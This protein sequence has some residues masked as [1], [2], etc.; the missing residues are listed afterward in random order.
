MNVCHMHALSGED[1][2][3]VRSPTN[4]V[5][6]GCQLPCGAGIESGSSAKP[7][8]ALFNHG[9]ISSLQPLGSALVSKD[10]VRLKNS[11]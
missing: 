1:T 4:V 3:A 10:T 6:G 9:T 7:A 11:T 8:S 2:F 5:T